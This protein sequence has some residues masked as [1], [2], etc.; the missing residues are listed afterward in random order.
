MKFSRWRWHLDEIFVK[1]N[2]KRD[3]LWRA[4]DH[5]GDALERF[6]TKTRDKKAAL[7]PLRKTTRKHGRPEAIVTDKLR[8]YGAA[9]NEI[10][11]D[12][13]Q[14][15]GRWLDE[16]AENSQLP[17]R[18]AGAMLR[19][20]RMRRL[21]KFSTV[22]AGVTNQLNQ[23]RSPS[24]REY[25]EASRIAALAEWHALRAARNAPAPG[26]LRLA[27]IRLT[28]HRR[29]PGP[30]RPRASSTASQDARPY[31]VRVG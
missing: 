7:Q 16:R 11:A 29:H 2:G 28:A 12:A 8:S 4:V 22:H 27:R 9:L 25:L 14:D 20:R 30:V 24:S 13:R 23:D 5:E 17:F 21:R 10:R 1:T 6:F 31:S 15:T 19:L 18:M 26:K 3:Y